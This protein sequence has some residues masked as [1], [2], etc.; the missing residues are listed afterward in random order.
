[1]TP[2]RLAVLP[3]L[4]LVA[5]LFAAPGLRPGTASPS[6][7]K[8]DGVATL[9]V[10]SQENTL[11][12]L[13]TVR[14]G[15]VHRLVHRRS[16]DGGASW[17]EDHV[18][19]TGPGGLLPSH[20]GN[21]P[22]VVTHGETVLVVW[23]RPG[24]SRFGSG[25]LGTARSLDGGQTW[26]AGP[27]PADD[28]STDGHGYVDAAA[29]PDGAFYLAWLDSRD[30]GQGLRAAVSRDG[31]RTW[32]TNASVDPRTCEC[33]WN[34]LLS[35]RTDAAF[36]L[37]RDKDPRDMAV[38][39]T[40]DGGRTWTRRAV[41]GA[42]GWEFDGCPHVGGALAATGEGPAARLHALSWTGALERGG[43]Y[44]LSSR[45]AGATWGEPLPIGEGK[46]RHGS[47]A[48][49][50]RALAVAWDEG[51][52]VRAA[53]SADEGAHLS[54]PRKLNADGSRASHPIVVGTSLGFRV[55]WTESAEGGS[56]ELRTATVTAIGSGP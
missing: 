49:S 31:G 46:A 27:N 2:L 51:G 43:L 54:P 22:Q 28:G 3:S 8:R 39:A 18:V 36:L 45:D 35:P 21:D 40:T 25:P 37:Y 9:D 42:F 10:W 50:G 33:C 7:E 23:T 15:E 29:G 53:V 47:L 14:A 5:A 26:A 30:G 56:S 44:L 13:L 55:L 38:A 4:L 48:A 12:L 20:R 34:S 32:S 17:S 11:D 16:K 41:V 19:D 1:M 52:S 24:T 6:H